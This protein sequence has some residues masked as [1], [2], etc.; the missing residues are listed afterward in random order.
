MLD[1]CSGSGGIICSTS[2][3]RCRAASNHGIQAVRAVV[4]GRAVGGIR[5]IRSEGE[6]GDK[7]VEEI[8]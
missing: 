6:G 3:R 4:L 5:D 7:R 2:V 1:R 8:V